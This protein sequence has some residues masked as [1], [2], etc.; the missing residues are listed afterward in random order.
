M[1]GLYPSGDESWSQN[2]MR[3]VA[4]QIKAVEHLIETSFASM[5]ELIFQ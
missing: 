2:L 4:P 1:P 3:T 5:E